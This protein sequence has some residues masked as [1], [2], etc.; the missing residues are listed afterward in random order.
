MHPPLDRP[1]P[2]CQD[3]IDA[4]RKC[5]AENSKVLFW[6]CNNAKAALDQCFRAEKKQMVQQATKD[7]AQV[8]TK[9]DS[10]MMEALGQKESFEEYLAKDKNYAKVSQQQQSNN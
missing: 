1:H 4:L 6:R 5:H 2:M 7:F 9:E 8:R 3:V 10:L